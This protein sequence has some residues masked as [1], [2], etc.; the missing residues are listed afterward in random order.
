MKDWA[1]VGKMISLCDV[2]QVR[3]HPALWASRAGEKISLMVPLY[4]LVSQFSDT[5][6]GGLAVTLFPGITV[7]ISKDGKLSVSSR[8]YVYA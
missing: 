7:L 1:K 2:P 8:N 4:A 6:D 5:R 3:R